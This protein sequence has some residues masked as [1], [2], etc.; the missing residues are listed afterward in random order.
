M[1]KEIEADGVNV[2]IIAKYGYQL[3]PIVINADQQSDMIVTCEQQAPGTTSAP[4]GSKL[5]DEYVNK[6]KLDG[7]DKYISPDLAIDAS[8]TL[9][10]DS[11]WYIQNMKHNCYPHVV[12]LLMYKILRH[13]GEKMTV[14]SDENYPQYLIYE[15]EENNGD[16]LRPMTQVDIGDPIEQPSFLELIKNI[17]INAFNIIL[18]QLKKLF[19]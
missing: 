8:T 7:T 3:Y 6:A 17:I 4:I 2:S 12:D 9:F 18:E 11:T 5:S 15:G 19:V 10:P 14:F 16:S 13:E 1:Y